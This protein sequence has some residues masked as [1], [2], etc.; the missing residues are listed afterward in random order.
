MQQA[1]PE[2]YQKGK[3]LIDQREK[4]ADA[5]AEKREDEINKIA[6][7]AAKYERSYL[8]LFAGGGV[9]ERSASQEGT[10]NRN[11]GTTLTAGMDLD[12]RMW[13][14]AIELFFRHNT[15]GGTTVS[16]TM[17]VVY[18]ELPLPTFGSVPTIAEMTGDPNARS[19]SKEELWKKYPN[20]ARRWM[21]SKSPIRIGIGTGFGG[22]ALDSANGT[23]ILA[24]STVTHDKSRASIWGTP[25]AARIGYFGPDTMARLTGYY[26]GSWASS[27]IGVKGMRDTILGQD[28]ISELVGTKGHYGELKLDIYHR[29][30]DR[31]LRRKIISG[32][33]VTLSYRQG[34]VSG[35]TFNRNLGVG[36]STAVTLPDMNFR[37][38]DLL[39]TIGYMR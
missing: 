1:E 25:V 33:G 4:T 27:D 18:L 12:S 11:T 30:D 16:N 32:Y 21:S 10:D 2:S 23:Q 34:S 15:G 38:A 22:V 39:F 13:P 20:E 8:Y 28:E 3:E 24:G 31:V 5:A 9:A 17:G 29:D 36:N 6:P 7:D 26:F 37:Q 35:Q 19:L 14:G